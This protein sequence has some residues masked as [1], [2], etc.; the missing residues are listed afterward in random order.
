MNTKA[1]ATSTFAISNCQQVLHSTL[2]TT[3]TTSIPSPPALPFLG[4]ITQLDKEIPQRTFDLLA[5]QYGEI[6]KLNL[7]TRQSLIVASYELLNELSN[8]KRFPKT[9][10]G[11]L[12]KMRN[13]M[14][15][16]LFSAYPGEENWGIAPP[17]K[18][19]SNEKENYID[20]DSTQEQTH[21]FV[22]AMV[23]F[24]IESANRANR[25]PIMNILMRSSSAKYQAD[26]K[27]MNHLV[28]ER[29]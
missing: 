8:D 15:D 18:C 3:M 2:A 24:L 22:Q 11:A 25:P 17:Q 16:G 7:I 23:D 10:V 21:S 1:P 14:G 9:V 19:S 27:I 20:G 26:L 12:E 28:D 6:Y 4:H 29:E 5:D 13:G